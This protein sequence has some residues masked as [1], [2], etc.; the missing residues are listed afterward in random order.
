MS[1][2]LKNQL[3]IRKKSVKSQGIFS[4][5]TAGNPDA[6]IYIHQVSLMFIQNCIALITLQNFHT[7]KSRESFS[8]NSSF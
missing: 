2:I 6:V 8:Y 7:A 4:E 5:F 3:Q 1:I